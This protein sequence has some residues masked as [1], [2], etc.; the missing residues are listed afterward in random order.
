MEDAN[1]KEEKILNLS[2]EMLGAVAGSVISI[3]TGQVGSLI[4]GAIGVVLTNGFKEVTNRYLSR[5][6]EIR[7]SSAT[8]ISITNIR[9]RLNQGD[10]PRGDDFFDNRIY[11]RSKAEEI[12]EGVLLKCKSEYEEEKIKYVAKIF[13][14]IAFN[15]AIDPEDANRVLN[16]VEQ[17]TYRQIKLIAFVGQNKE[18]KF[19]IRATDYRTNEEPA[20]ANSTFILQD[21][22]TLD[23]EAIIERNDNTLII[24]VSDIAPGN[25]VLTEIGSVY[26]N[27]LGL[28]AMPKEAFDFVKLLY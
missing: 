25:M 16:T 4:G 18:N 8:S 26:Y 11:N 17:L 28:D 1:N 21:L 12:F 2:S 22:V 23:G 15:E 10:K 7:V 9:N 6:E 5:R 24:H 14:N 19:K 3:T 13:E 27:L 20:A